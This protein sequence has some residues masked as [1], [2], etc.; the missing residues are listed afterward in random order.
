LSLNGRICIIDDSED[1]TITFRK[2]LEEYGYKVDTYNDPLVA[3]SA[4]QPESYDLFLIDIRMPK[5]NGFELG[6]KIRMKDQ[7]VKICFITAFQAYY[8]SLLEEYPNI[9]HRC[10]I[11]KPIEINS[12][13]NTIK[14]EIRQG[15]YNSSLL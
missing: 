6:R 10:F 5:M 15:N 11:S 12:L 7:S 3:L 9:D 2:G 14:S 13:A 4:V 1:I 8:E